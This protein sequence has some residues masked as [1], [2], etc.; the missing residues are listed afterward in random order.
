MG[1]FHLARAAYVAAVA[2]FTVVGCQA[3]HGY[4]YDKA[5]AEAA[6][7]KSFRMDCS[8]RTFPNCDF[9]EVSVRIQTFSEVTLPTLLCSAVIIALAVT[10]I[11]VGLV[12]RLIFGK[13]STDGQP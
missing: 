1:I 5:V 8:G 3:I 10:F 13:H 12:P 9:T 4:W 6:Q 2:W 11:V 7:T